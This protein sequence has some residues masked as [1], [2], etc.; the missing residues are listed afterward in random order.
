V[1][2]LDTNVLVRYLAQDDK[3]Q[4]ARATKFIETQLSD[5]QPGFIGLVV[6][7]EL[8]WVLKRLY[9]ATSADLGQTV[10]DLLDS[11]QLML[12]HRDVVIVAL[13]T[14][15]SGKADFSDALIAAVAA[16]AGCSETVTFDKN[17]S[18]LPGV[19]LLTG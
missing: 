3:I 18:K 12:E 2:G 11:R 19:T 15:I 10:Q 9:S 4:S 13:Q 7:V 8:C 1:S 6:L 5:T 16:G 14:F 17:A